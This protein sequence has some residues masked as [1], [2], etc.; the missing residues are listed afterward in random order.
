MT[1]FFFA[2]YITIF[3]YLVFHAVVQSL[4]E[5]E[6]A[7]RTLKAKHRIHAHSF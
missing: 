6:L 4:H 7:G 3:L 1:S 2:S 5:L